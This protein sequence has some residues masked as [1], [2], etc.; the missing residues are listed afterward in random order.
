[1]YLQIKQGP[2]EKESHAA[3]NGDA[4]Y[5]KLAEK[6]GEVALAIKRDLV[7]INLL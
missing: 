4:S 2:I 6:L 5:N 1:M 3:V 7:R